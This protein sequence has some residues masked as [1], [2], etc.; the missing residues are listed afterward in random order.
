MS[1]TAHWRM[2]LPAARRCL[3][4]YSNVTG[5]GLGCGRA[6][7]RAH[8]VWRVYINPASPA[9]DLSA[10]RLPTSLFGLPIE[11]FHTQP[12]VA[13]AKAP[14]VYTAGM[15]I[16]SKISGSLL[17]VGSSEQ[18]SLGCFARDSAGKPVLLTNS[19]VMFP[20]FLAL[21]HLGIYQP[22]YSSCCS[23]GDK[24]ATPVFDPAQVKDGKFKGGFKMINLM[25]GVVPAPNPRG[26]T[27]QKIV[28]SSETD[29]AIARLDPRVQFSNVLR[30]PAD[31]VPGS[32][33]PGS[34]VDIA[35]NGSN[36]DVLSVLGPKAGT[37]PAPDQYV[38]VFTPRGGG[39]LIF[40]T[41]TWTPHSVADSDS[42]VVDGTRQTP[43]FRDAFVIG[44]PEDEERA[45][46]VPSI[47]QFVILPRPKPIPGETDY[48]KFYKPNQD[49]S[50]DFGD[51]GSVVIDHLGRV[52]AQIIGGFPFIPDLFV[53]KESDRSR[54]E[55]TE[56]RNVGI[57]SPIRGIIEQL[58]I[59]IPPAGFSGTVPAAAARARVFVPGVPEN[60]RLESDREIVQR[61]RERLRLTRRGTLVLGK[62]AQHRREVRQLLE[63]VR[64]IGAVW[65]DLQGPGFYHH[66]VQSARDDQHVIPTSINSITRDRLIDGLLPLLLRHASPALRRDLTR[67]QAWARE[68]FLQVAMLDDVP[69]L[70]ARRRTPA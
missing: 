49:L 16:E 24:I 42:M 34:T 21:S 31:Q 12:G 7:A 44:S 39:R 32:A 5:V 54:I 38:R 50:F 63:R 47:N 61:L 43:I 9:D 27:K 35:I 45:G 11:L 56:V 68:V 59:T 65:R 62:I 57:A 55:F 67:Y 13:A 2:L 66:C 51:S 41:I 36:D 40:G 28:H 58:T 60:S 25:G 20:H 19:H 33:K 10:V 30:V 48:T 6:R 52:I 18:G 14:T 1:R 4:A 70:V 69:L 37:T 53:K 17:T 8:T 64:A 15:P 46:S 29:C 3:L 23:S 26:W 22:D